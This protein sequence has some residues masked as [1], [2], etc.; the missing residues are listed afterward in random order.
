[1]RGLNRNKQTLYYALYEGMTEIVDSNGN[2]T[3]EYTP[4]YSLPVKVKM[5]IAPA[6]GNADWDPFGISTPYTRVAM[7][8]EKL[9]ISETSIVWVDKDPNEPHNYV[10]TAIARS[11]NNTA[12]AL[13]EVKDGVQSQCQSQY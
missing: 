5:N 9:P 10:V 12:Y 6:Q 13:Y 8:C 3:G 7:T 11:L 1:M 4:S 2:R